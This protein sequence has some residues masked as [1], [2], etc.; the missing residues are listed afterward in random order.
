MCLDA[1]ATYSV[2]EL[3][4]AICVVSANAA[5][6]AIGDYLCGSEANFVD[7][8]NNWLSAWGVNGYFVDCTGVSSRN[9]NIA[10]RNGN[11]SQQAY[12]RLSRCIKLYEFDIS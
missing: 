11:S 2:D 4:G 5:V 10:E 6:M 9:K 8:M 3:L 12:K 7:E 1:G